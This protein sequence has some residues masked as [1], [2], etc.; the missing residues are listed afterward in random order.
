MF[1]D[2]FWTCLGRVW[3]ILGHFWDIFGTGFV[4]LTEKYQLHNCATS[5]SQKALE[6]FI[7]TLKGQNNFGNRMLF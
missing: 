1:W 4:E 2:I 3:D 6:Q 5:A 7:Q